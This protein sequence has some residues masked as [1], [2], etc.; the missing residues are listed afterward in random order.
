MIQLL[1]FNLLLIILIVLILAITKKT[2][3]TEKGKNILLL[4]VA[5]STILC[6]YSSLLY[7]GLVDN[8]AMKFLDENPNLLLPIYPCNLVM[9]SC[10]I[11]GLL[12]S[13]D[14]KVG[15]FLIDYMFWFGIISS[16]V[17]MIVNIDYFNNPTLLDYDVTKGIVAHAIM[18]LNV[19]ILPVFGFVEIK[20]EKNLFHIICSIILMYV[21]GLYCN[22]A[23][24]VIGS[25]EYA[26]HVNSM[27]IIHSPFEQVT[28]LKYPM[29]ALIA[30]GCYFIIFTICDMVKFPS[31]KRWYNR[32]FKIKKGE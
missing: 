22:L 4:V 8:S 1:L 18:L 24:E 10:L 16:L 17:G 30:L 9:W 27:F 12:K 2:I 14:S 13:K 26:Y 3:K 7:H 6:H 21:V 28:F 32:L 15:S 25:Y 31:S 20:F 5:L 29:I 11:L 19:L 23:I